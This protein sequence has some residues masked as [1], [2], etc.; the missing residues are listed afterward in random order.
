MEVFHGSIR[1]TFEGLVGHLSGDPSVVALG[2]FGSWARGEGTSSSDFDVLVVEGSGFD[3]E[4]GEVEV[5]GGLV[6]D[7]CRVPL[8][9]LGE[10]LSPQLDYRLHEAVVL[11]DP[12]GVLGAAKGFVERIFM[13]RRRVESR[14][15]GLLA[16]SEMQLSRAS[17][18]LMR[19]DS[20]TAS[21]YVGAGLASAA[22][23]LMDVA[24]VPVT[25]RQFVWGLRRACIKMGV[26]GIY[27]E[28]LERSGVSSVGR[29]EASEA[30][31]GF[32][33]VWRGVSSFIS[34]HGDVLG[35]LH[36]KLRRDVE[37]MTAEPVLEGILSR[38]R[39]MVGVGNM[40]EA[41]VYLRG[42]MLPLL[43][44]FAWVAAAVEG[45]KYDYTSLFRVVSGAD[46]GLREGA[47]GVLGLDGVSE[48]AARDALAGARQLVG[49]LRL[50]RRR[51]VDSFVS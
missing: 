3:Y 48:R 30:A 1:G 45:E 2:L 39:E 29:G 21:A 15:E 11:H 31:D 43:E 18:A 49:D 27:R 17:A 38:V 34:V 20:E 51:L 5:R 8:G 26:E 47:L 25:R 46:V 32:E 4:Y 7:L 9:W 12:E 13:S 22:V 35:G 14:T 23:V 19:G 40:A 33:E 28:F 10:P 16:T 41:V 37:Y 44:G 50:D 36:G 24:G 6:V 42:W